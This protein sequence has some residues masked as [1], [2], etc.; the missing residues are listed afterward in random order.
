MPPPEKTI[1]RCKTWL[2]DHVFPLWTQSGISTDGDFLEALS[3]DGEPIDLPRR[4]MVQA[5]QIYAFR[6]GAALGACPAARARVIVAR[7]A[8][9]LI[10]RYSLASGAFIHSLGTD[11]SPRG[12]P[13]LYTQAFALFGLAN[14]YAVS[15]DEALKRRALAVLDY[16]QRER[17][18]LSA[19][20][21]EF[22]GDELVL[23]SNP[24]M[25]LFEAA[26]NWM[27]VDPSS[28]WSDLAG[29]ILHL[30]LGAFID[31]DTGALCE[32]FQA[33]WKPERVD[34]RFFFEPGHH[35]EWSWLM[36]LHQE[37][38]GSPCPSAGR[39]FQI[40]EKAGLNPD[41]FA[42]DEVWSHGVPKKRS[43]RFW[44]QGE[45]VK[46]AVRLGVHAPQTE[47]V[48]YARA[49]DQA[50]DALLRFLETPTPGIWRDT[51]LESGVFREEPAKAS[52][53][54]HIINAIDEYV[55]L[56]PRL[57]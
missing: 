56:R 8:A 45:R 7:A 36:T 1:E 9:R 26:L 48:A 17:R 34:S 32:R 55:A 12:K 16:L 28:C 10:D 52:S 30:C 13:D 29:E 46:A 47:Q 53:L 39:L 43:S 24:H 42:W 20:Y 25:H 18:A 31:P 23:R 41:G 3:L 49:A 15:P 54:Y 35:Y 14:A 51:R 50:L 19:G 33:E 6:V 4:A 38:T 44:P 2:S 27:Q 40:A 11:G 37:L 57:G 22:E 5:R 21:T